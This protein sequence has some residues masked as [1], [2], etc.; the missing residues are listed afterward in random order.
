M[1][2]RSSTNFSYS[3]KPG[4]AASPR[5]WPMLRRGRHGRGALLS[6]ERRGA[7]HP[8]RKANVPPLR[9]FEASG[10]EKHRAPASQAA[11]APEQVDGR[12]PVQ[13][14]PAAGGTQSYCG[15]Q[16][17]GRH[18][19]CHAPASP[20]DV[21]QLAL[22]PTRMQPAAWLAPGCGAQVSTSPSS[23]PDVRVDL[24]APGV[25]V[26]LAPAGIHPVPVRG[27]Q[28]RGVP[29]MRV[30]VCGNGQGMATRRLAAG[31]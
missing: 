15:A 19:R 21:R 8:P 25:A 12:W 31:N 26:A 27:M 7:S 18:A 9:G 23:P 13:R 30:S 4:T 3:L 22:A 11:A 16:S 29:C 17:E 28:V 6:S 14:V 20:P 5:R 1:S 10:V 2:A 24:A